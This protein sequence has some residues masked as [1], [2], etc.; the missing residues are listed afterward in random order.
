MYNQN[1]ITKFSENLTDRQAADAVAG[2]IDWKY[3]LGLELTNPGFN[4]S[5]LSEFRER[6]IEGKAEHLLFEKMLNQFKEQGLLKAKGKQRTDSTH[7]LAAIRTLSRLEL[8]TE[9][10]INALNVLA[11][12][13]PHWLKTWVPHEWYNRYEKRIS[14][15]HLPDEDKERLA[16]AQ[17]VGIDGYLYTFCFQFRLENKTK[18]VGNGLFSYCPLFSQ[19]SSSG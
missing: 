8:V 4:F 15:Y 13:T 5:V 1:V 14:E 3:A 10:L 18:S 2:R 16:F 19:G 17:A 12:V 11:T 9:T 7:I 6:L